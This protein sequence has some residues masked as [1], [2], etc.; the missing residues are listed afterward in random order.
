[1]KNENQMIVFC[2]NVK[3]LREKNGLSQREMAKIMAI[4]VN[5]LKK[6]EE[7]IMP[8][9]M[10]VKIIFKLSRYF[11]IKPCELFIRLP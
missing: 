11:Y 9:R 4:S 6:I 2:Q 1:M 5:S 7:E 10:S 8:P 3:V